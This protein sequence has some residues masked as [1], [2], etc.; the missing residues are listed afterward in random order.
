MAK[1]SVNDYSTTAGN[2]TDVQSINIDEGMAPSN[3]NNAMRQIMAHVG[4]AFQGGVTVTSIKAAAFAAQTATITSLVLGA[5]TATYTA[6]PATRAITAGQGLTGGGTF[7]ADREINLDLSDLTATAT[8]AE[9]DYFGVYRTGATGTYKVLKSDLAGSTSVK[10][11]VELATEGETQ[12]LTATGVAVTPAAMATLGAP[13][14]LETLATT[15][16][17]SATSG[18]LPACRA[19]F[20]L[21]ED[22][23]GSG[24]AALQATISAN[25]TDYSGNFMPT[26]TQGSTYERGGYIWIF[27]TGV[28]GSKITQAVIGAPTGGDAAFRTAVVSSVTGVIT[29]IRFAMSAGSFDNGAV[30]IFGFR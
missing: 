18:A 23:S 13:I 6:V 28:T 9:A 16:G 25:G 10:G 24:T 12:G 20:C 21:F 15:S 4:A 17:T 19:F 29:R 30:H 5:G 1:N 3:V 14:L 11:F 27:G 8:W 26:N 7:E 22:I 2:N